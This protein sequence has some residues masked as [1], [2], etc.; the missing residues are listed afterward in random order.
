MN[1]NFINLIWN[2]FNWQGIIKILGC[3]RINGDNSFVS[4][5]QPFIDLFLWNF[6]LLC[7]RI[8]VFGKNLKTLMDIID[9]ILP[10]N[11]ILLSA[12]IMHFE[13]SQGFCL[14]VTSFSNAFNHSTMRPLL[15][16]SPILILNDVI[17]MRR[18]SSWPLIFFKFFG[19]LV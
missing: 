6:P 12:N 10:F 16:N 14:E 7:N 9:L 4:Q 5:V 8:N 13:Q 2:F 11:F 17:P 1:T 19:H 3:D 15:S 18:V